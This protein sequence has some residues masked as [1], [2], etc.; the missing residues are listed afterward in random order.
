[1]V[2]VL[3]LPDSASAIGFQKCGTCIKRGGS[4][5]RLADLQLNTGPQAV[6]SSSPVGFAPDLVGMTIAGLCNMDIWKQICG[7]IPDVELVRSRL[8]C[9]DF[10]KMLR[11]LISKVH[12][13]KP[14]AQSSLE[15]LAKTYPNLAA[16]DISLSHVDK[17]E[18]LNWEDVH[19]P[20]LRHLHLHCCPLQSNVFTEA[21]TPSLVTLSIWE[22]EPAAEGFKISLPEL[23][24]LDIEHVKVIFSRRLCGSLQYAD[25]PYQ[26]I[27]FLH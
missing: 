25:L 20:S 7:H 2:L 27:G 9:K 5:V 3:L 23:T 8:V 19:L 1:M 11:L 21:N 17:S 18:A 6:Q 15:S 14:V 10:D 16:L 4:C 13:R 24:H 12:I 22:Q 26:T